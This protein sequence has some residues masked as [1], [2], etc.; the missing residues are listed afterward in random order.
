MNTTERTVVIIKPDGVQRGI[1][2]EILHRFERRGLKLIGMKFLKLPVEL[3]EEHYAHHKD[4]PFFSKL[5][6]FMTS[7]PALA[8]VLEGKDGVNVVRAMTGPT[9]GT[10]AFPGTIRGDFALSHQ[11]NVIHA[12]ES[13]EIANQE[14]KRFFDDRE[15]FDDYQRAD[16]PMVYAE[17]ERN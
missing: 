15:L 1:I 4:K 8:M 6:A 11:Q 3:L 5:I 10:D 7:A 13:I 14:V 12:S 16:W 2:G 17:D 9:K